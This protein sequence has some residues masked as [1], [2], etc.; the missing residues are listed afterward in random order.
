MAGCL[1]SDGGCFCDADR[2]R[3][4]SHSRGRLKMKWE[5]WEV[6]EREGK[7]GSEDGGRRGRE[8]EGER[9]GGWEG[10]GHGVGEE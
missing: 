10:G 3:N 1:S 6:R 8:G 4:W 2:A 5:A 7:R 9:D